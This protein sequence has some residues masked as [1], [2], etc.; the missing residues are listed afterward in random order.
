[1]GNGNVYMIV[2]LVI[3]VAYL[4]FGMIRPTKKQT[5]KRLEMSRL[6]KK[7]DPI[8]N[9]GGL[10]GVI[11]YIEL[12]AGTVV[13]DTD[14]IYLTLHLNAVRGVATRP[15]THTPAPADKA[16]ATHTDEQRVE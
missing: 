8:V 11:D 4:Y 1:M 16:E 14:G 13:I 7:G 9:I 15:D 10:H 3:F 2:L 12:T 5:T 6:L